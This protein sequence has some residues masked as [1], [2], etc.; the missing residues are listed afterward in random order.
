MQGSR[1]LQGRGILTPKYRYRVRTLEITSL[2]K[3]VAW[4]CRGSVWGEADILV[5]VVRGRDV[6]I[7]WG[8]G[9]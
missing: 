1:E 4:G 3:N 7:G 9:F 2:F 6:E 8:E 5:E